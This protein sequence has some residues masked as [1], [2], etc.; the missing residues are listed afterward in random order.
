MTDEAKM[1]RLEYQRAYRERN[2]E[3]VREYQRAWHKANPEKASEYQERHWIKVA[4][5]ANEQ[6]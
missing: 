4:E 2:R 1:K 6:K 5:G 3:K